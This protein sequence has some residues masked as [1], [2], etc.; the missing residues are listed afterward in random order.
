MFYISLKNLYL[1][2]YLAVLIHDNI[3]GSRRCNVD[4]LPSQ[5]IIG[6]RGNTIEPSGIE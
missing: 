1:S 4:N 5:T 3:Y 2:I 6:A